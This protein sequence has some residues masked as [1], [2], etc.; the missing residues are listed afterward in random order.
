[1]KIRRTVSM[2]WQCVF[3]LIYWTFST[4]RHCYCQLTLKMNQAPRVFAIIIELWD[5]L[6]LSTSLDCYLRSL[7]TFY[8]HDEPYLYW[9]NENSSSK[10]NT[11]CDLLFKTQNCVLSAVIKLSR[12]V[13]K[14]NANKYQCVRHYCIDLFKSFETL[15][16]LCVV[17][18]I[19]SLDNQ[20]HDAVL[21]STGLVAD[22]N[23][24]VHGQAPGVRRTWTQN[25]H[26]IFLIIL[27]TDLRAHWESY[28]AVVVIVNIAH[29]S[30][31]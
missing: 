7:G 6:C 25:V 3:P 13:F 24:I 20:D 15:N 31:V 22:D 30:I 16:N 12:R 21:V 4:V 8:Q 19:S 28:S 27:Q 9:I 14:K 29:G 10:K 11:Q 23:D 26:R 2:R 18:W 17:V 5:R 1:M